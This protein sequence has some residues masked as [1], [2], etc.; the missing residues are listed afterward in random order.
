MGLRDKYAYAIDTA[1]KFHM[2]GSADERDGKLYFHGTVATQDEANT[3]W[4]AIKTIPEW[5]NEV[6]AD[7][8]AT[9]AG[10]STSASSERTYTVKSG[11]T[12]S[13]IAKEMLGD[14]GAYMDIF[15]ANRDQLSDPN[16]IKPGQVLKIPQHTTH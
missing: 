4:D 2:Q 6:V 11:D 10:A 14:S 9:G 12:L 7:V 15:N 8:K 3:I 13:R 16:K 1:K 5:P